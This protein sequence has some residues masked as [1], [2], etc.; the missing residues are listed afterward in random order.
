MGEEHEESDNDFEDAGEE[1][2]ESEDNFEDTAEE[3]DESGDETV[4]DSGDVS[5]DGEQAEPS[6]DVQNEPVADD[7]P[8]KENL[9][10]VSV[11]DDGSLRVTTPTG[12]EI[13]Y[14]RN[15]DGTY[16]MPTQTETGENLVDE[17]GNAMEPGMVTTQEEILK[18]AQWYKDNEQ[19]MLAERA[20]EDARQQAERDRLAAENAK[21]LENERSK[22]GQLSQTSID[23]MNEER[24][25]K[26]DFEHEVL[27]D[28]IGL[29]HG[30]VEDYET[31]NKENIMKALKRDT[32]KEYIKGGEYEGEAAKWDERI[33][34]AQETKFV[35]DQ[36]VNA[37]GMLTHDPVLPKAY[38]AA[39]NYAETLTDAHVNGKDMKQ[40]LVKA[41]VDTGIDL[42]VDKGEDYGFTAA[43]L[44]N[45][46]G[47]GVKQMN[48]NLYDG[49]EI[50]D[51]VYDSMKG[52][53]VTGLVSGGAGKLIQVS[54]GTALD[55][56]I[57]DIGPNTRLDFWNNPKVG[58]VDADVPTGKVHT[59]VETGGMR[60]TSIA[61]RRMGEGLFKTNTPDVQTGKPNVSDM[62]TS[63]PNVS[64]M[65]TSKPNVS[66]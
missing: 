36:T 48:D 14:T 30:T 11:D 47:S 15:E 42:V 60:Q 27:L 65:Q 54:K 13:V 9:D 20:E 57:A 23:L 38:N 59:D 21:W 64:D 46:L 28:K 3:N 39:S 61:E 45:T 33:V 62:Q 19:A 52:G 32:I 22:Y 6:D 5:E 29:K 31:K 8:S 1:S 56:K 17:N 37:Y 50:T 63:K 12:E 7:V 35:V 49:R 16:N 41:T 34:T 24:Q 55:T 66:D 44:S 10:N 58:N 4:S 18:G 2:E 51:G 26:I 40:A 53:A 25:R 43:V